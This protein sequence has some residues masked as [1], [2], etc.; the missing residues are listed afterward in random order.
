M[1]IAAFLILLAAVF[2]KPAEA[3][4]PQVVPEQ[5]LINLFALTEASAALKICSDSSSFA[6]LTA[7]DQALL[8]RLQGTIERLVQ[9]IARKYDENLFPFFLQTRQEAAARPDKIKEMR[10]KYKFCGNDLLVQMNRYVTDSHQ[11]LDYFLSQQPDA[12]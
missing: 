12:K 4:R 6:S 8:Q 1:K 3:K 9:T 5:M 11:K 10:M 7:K 2:A